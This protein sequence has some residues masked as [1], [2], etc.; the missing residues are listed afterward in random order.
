MTWLPWSLV[1]FRLG[2]G[3][4]L[5]LDARDG[6]TGW[7]FVA[8]L[9]AGLLSDIVDGMLARKLNLASVRLRRADSLVD[10]IFFLFVAAAAWAAHSET[11]L[12]H[13]VLAAG[14]FA[15]WAVSQLPALLK[16]GKAAAY[17]AYSAK[18]AGL[19]LLAAGVR[20]F[21]LGQGGWVLEAALWLAILSHLERIA[22][23][24]ALPAWRT[25]VAWLGAALAERRRL[26]N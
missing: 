12:A 25:D 13:G 21:G 26:E 10:S 9:I 2:M 16:F 1:A 8:G 18:A 15:L 3:P 11:L 23:T 4:F 14:M 5:L 17:H 19:A 6:E 7:V 24:L 20:L 22:I